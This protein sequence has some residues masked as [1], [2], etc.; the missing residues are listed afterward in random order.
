[1]FFSGCS[2]ALLKGLFFHRLVCDWEKLHMLLGSGPEAP[3]VNRS[4][5]CG[6]PLVGLVLR[7]QP[8][9]VLVQL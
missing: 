2:V 6:N 9:V 1:M 7:T 3:V 8:W 5:H 4:V